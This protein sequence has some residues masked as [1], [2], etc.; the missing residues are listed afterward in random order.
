[1]VTNSAIMWKF[2]RI[3]RRSKRMIVRWSLKMRTNILRRST[4]SP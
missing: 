2:M 3:K 1:M 4:N